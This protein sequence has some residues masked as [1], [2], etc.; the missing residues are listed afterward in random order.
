MAYIPASFLGYTTNDN[1]WYSFISNH[2]YLA[3]LWW[4]GLEA[5]ICSTSL[6]S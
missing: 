3:I 4:E 6:A 5:Q 1:Y 2:W